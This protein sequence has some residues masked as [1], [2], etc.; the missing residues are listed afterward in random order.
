MNSIH[1]ELFSPEQKVGG[2]NPL[3]RTT[4]LRNE[5]LKR[6]DFSR[7]RI[8]LLLR[9]QRVDVRINCIPRVLIDPSLCFSLATSSAI[10]VTLTR[11]RCPRFKELARS[12]DSAV[13]SLHSGL[14]FP[15]SPYAKSS[16]LFAAL[17]CGPRS[18][19]SSLVLAGRYAGLTHRR[20]SHERY[21]PLAPPDGNVDRPEGRR[22]RGEPLQVPDCVCRLAVQPHHHISLS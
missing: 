5:L 20:L 9:V 6:I 16:S 11:W 21:L 22:L 14:P 19:L 3:G 15:R 18:P 4:F 12:E 17:R 8:D 2:S 10:S 13:E 1:I 7:F